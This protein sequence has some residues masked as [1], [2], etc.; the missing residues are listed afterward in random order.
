MEDQEVQDTGFDDFISAFGDGE[1]YQTDA[2]Q[3]EQE[4]AESH[5]TTDHD[6]ENQ[7]QEVP[8]AEQPE[9]DPEKQ[10]PAT[11]DGQEP[12]KEET[13]ELKVN[14]ETRTYSREEMIA[15]AQKGV[16]YDRVKEQLKEQQEAMD[17]LSDLAKDSGTDIPGLLKT[18]R[19]NMLKKQG[20]SDDAAQER[21][22][23]EEA[24][25][26]NAKLKKER[27]AARQPGEDRQ[28]KIRREVTEFREL[29]PN[30]QLSNELLQKLT[31]EVQ[32][33]KSLTEAYRGYEAAQKDAR[34]AELERQLAAEKQNK[35]N[36][37]A[38]PG[39]QKDSGGK[40]SKSDFDD[41]MA[42]FA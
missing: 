15:F 2:D 41:F 38:S 35:A 20:L 9:A 24:E 14:K 5:D 39:S 7:E 40:R 17:V 32:K 31:P 3:V 34:I 16:D 22:L 26:E 27:D 6:G 21:L 28:E 8:P 42:A 37:A 13:F 33:G 4:E 36:R 1:G 19:L 11:T 18:F 29:Y 10:E 25:R 30:V 12:V 23:R